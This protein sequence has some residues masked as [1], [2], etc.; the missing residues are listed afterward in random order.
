MGTL[1]CPLLPFNIA[2]ALRNRFSYFNHFSTSISL[3]PSSQQLIHVKSDNEIAFCI[4]SALQKCTSLGS[5]KKIHAKIFAFGLQDDAHLST[6]S[7]L[8]YISFNSVDD[9]NVLFESIPHPSCYLWNIII[10]GYATEGQF[11][12]ALGSYVNMMEKGLTPDKYTF[13]FA[14]KSCARLADLQIGKLVHQHSVCCGCGSDVFVEAALVDMYVKCGDINSARLMFDKM[15]KRDLV[16]WTSMISG[17]AHNGYNDETMEFFDMMRGSGIKANRVGILSVLLASGNLGALRKGEEFHT[18]VV[19]TGFE[20]DILVAT[21]VMDMYAKCGNIG[22]SRRLFDA[23]EGKDVVCWS[24]MIACYGIHGHGQKAINLFNEMIKEGLRPNHVT[25]TCVL[26]ACSHSGLLEEGKKYFQLMRRE[27]RIAPKLSNYACMVDLLGRAG[28]LSEA[29]ELIESMPVRPDTSIWGS[30][31]GA[32][33]V[34]SNLDLAER[35]A[36]HIFQLDPFHAG[37]HVLLSNI[38]AAKSRWNDVEKVRMMMTR[39]GANKVQGISLIE[40]NNL[41]HKFGVGDRSHPQSEKIYAL[42]EELAGPMK[43]LGYVPL[44]DFVLHDI[45]DEAKEVALS[46]HSERLAIAFGLINTS[47]GT[48][49][50]ITKNLRICGDCHNAIKFISRIV[51]RVIIVRDMHRFHHFENGVCSCGDYW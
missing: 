9:A 46:Y 16:C 32:C 13:P 41:V 33:R 31:L 35:I 17:Y 49:L 44:T 45:E 15:E 25:F 42:L 20:S 4:S 26:S 7:S 10:K 3:S 6:K 21:A 1:F 14:L 38:Y 5:L 22:L 34:H 18:Y 8:L 40:L 39:R 36:D 37:Y 12:R 50:R 29:E 27:L 19:K 48:T 51:N 24:A 23:T 2:V 30:L 28:E 47:P 11:G 43:R